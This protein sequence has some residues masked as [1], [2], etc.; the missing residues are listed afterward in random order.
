MN[1]WRTIASLASR[2]ADKSDCQECPEGLP[3]EDPGFS[4]AV[5]ALGAK[6]AMADG[7]ADPGE[8][9][10]FSEAFRANS[11]GGARDVQRL[12]ALAG[13]TTRGFESYARQI[14]KRYRGC[15]DLL[16]DVMGGLFHIAKADGAVT[17]D[18]IA[19]LQRVA[20]LFG[21]SPLAFRRL[22]AAFLGA[23]ADDPYVILGVAP[24]ASDEAVRTAWRT[25][26]AESHPD[27]AAG[28]GL[29]PEFVEAAHERSVAINAAYEQVNRERRGLL[30]AAAG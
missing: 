14:G 6:L 7:R 12:Y 4:A 18:E 20:E 13:Q 21:L 8:F 3:G 29:G 5:T 25:L 17:P 22:K 26:L 19:Y 10:A 11:P 27:R 2:R 15:P 28:L 30:A 16:E 1:L 24:D 23:P 9:Q